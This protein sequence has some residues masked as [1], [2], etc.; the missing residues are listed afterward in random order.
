MIG[1]HVPEPLAKGVVNLRYLC[2][3]LLPV[4]QPRGCCATVSDLTV[5]RVTAGHRGKPRPSLRSERATRATRTPGIGGHEG[6]TSLSESQPR[7]L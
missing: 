4:S 6:G 5:Q 1:W 7:V 2:S 3:R